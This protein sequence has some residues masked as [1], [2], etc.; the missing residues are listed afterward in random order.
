MFNEKDH[1]GIPAWSFFLFVS[2]YIDKP[3]CSSFRVHPT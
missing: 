3:Q 1:V 2:P